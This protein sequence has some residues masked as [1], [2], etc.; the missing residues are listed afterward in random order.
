ML[1][2]CVCVLSDLTWLDLHGGGRKSWYFNI[3]LY[4]NLS[5]PTEN[6]IN[7]MILKY[8]L[9]IINRHTR[10]TPHS[11]TLIDNI[12]CNRVDEVESSW[13]I[14][15]II[16][17]DFFPSPRRGSHVKSDKNTHTVIKMHHL[18]RILDS[19]ALIFSSC[20]LFTVYPNHIM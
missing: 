4:H 16:Y 15:I 17:H 14:I 8:F 20:A 1:D 11:C 9:P 18:A 12:F 5:P 19:W 2:D 10:A 7:Q 13:V 3:N 6:F